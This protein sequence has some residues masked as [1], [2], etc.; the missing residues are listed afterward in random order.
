M[1]SKKPPP[2]Y[3]RRILW[4]IDLRDAGNHLYPE[5]P[6]IMDVIKGHCG[7]D[8]DS[9]ELQQ[10]VRETPE[11]STADSEPDYALKPGPMKTAE[12]VPE[13]IARIKAS[14]GD[15]VMTRQGGDQ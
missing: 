3:H 5:A 9:R 6:E 8:L 7:A 10:Q 11:R 15:K 4:L 12:E 2:D 13:I 14:S 1:K